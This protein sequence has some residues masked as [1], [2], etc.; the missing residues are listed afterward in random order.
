[1]TRDLGPCDRRPKPWVEPDP[2]RSRR[3][4]VKR[5][6][7]SVRRLCAVN[8]LARLVTLT[9]RPEL[10]TDDRAELL[11]RMQAFERR[12][13]KALPS[14]RWVW[15]AEEHKSG[16]LHVHMGVDRWVAKRTWAELWGAGFVDV[17][18]LKSN[19]DGAQQ[20][21]ADAARY[22][23]KYIAKCADDVEKGGHRF[24]ASRT[25]TYD[26]ERLV[27]EHLW[28]AESFVSGHMVVLFATYVDSRTSEGWRGPPCWIYYGHA[29]AELKEL[30]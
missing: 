16:M 24:F 28:Q 7:R 22:L 2:E 21:A 23:A 27:V 26:L 29:S 15:V 20:G 3:E 4:S 13:N 11:K 17:R 10:A 25:C 9:M 12:V 19:R 18:R 1:M 8:R 5:S 6:V 14:L 30:K